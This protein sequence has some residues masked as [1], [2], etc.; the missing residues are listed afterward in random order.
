[1][2]L[3]PLFLIGMLVIPTETHD[4]QGVLRT[5]RTW[6]SWLEISTCGVTIL[7]MYSYISSDND[8]PT[9]IPAS[10]IGPIIFQW[11]K[12]IPQGDERYGVLDLLA[13]MSSTRYVLEIHGERDDR[14]PIV[15]RLYL[16]PAGISENPIPQAPIR[17]DR[18][19]PWTEEDTREMSDWIIGAH[20]WMHSKFLRTFQMLAYKRDM[21]ITFPSN[22]GSPGCVPNGL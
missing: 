6:S 7:R 11:Y 16:S 9:R 20:R 13:D 18:T 19:G 10:T 2:K 4:G 8:S 21:R 15:V 14:V 22:I 3:L 1:M 5:D 17:R 12:E